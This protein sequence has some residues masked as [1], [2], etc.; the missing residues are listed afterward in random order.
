M[1]TCSSVAAPTMA[2]TW[3]SAATTSARASAPAQLGPRSEQEIR[4]GLEDEIGA[5]RWTSL[6][7]S[8]PDIS[9]EGGG[10][11]DLRPGGVGEDPELRRL[12]IGRAAKLERLGLAEQI[13]PAQWTLKPGLE[14]ALRD[15]GI[16]GDN[17][18][19]MHRAMSG[20]EREPDVARF[21]L[22]GDLPAERVLGRLV[23]RGLHDELKGTAY[24]IVDGVDGRTHYL[25]FSD[26]EM[27]GDAKPGA[28]VETRAYDDA[29]GRKRLSLATRSDLTVDAQV[30]ARG[31][32]WLDRQ[33][34]A[35]ESA[36][37]SGGFGAEVRDAMDRRIN[38]LIEHDLA[39]RQGQR[40]L[41]AR[42][43]L[44]TLRRR[45]LDATAASLSAETGLA[46]RPSGEGD[47]VSGVYR[48]RVT[49]ATGRF[50]MI[51]DGMGFQLVP[52]RPALEQQLGKQIGG[53]MAP[54]GNV[55]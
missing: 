52:W 26:L 17:I 14:L 50:A 33:L 55:D 20:A 7:R 36:L 8:L 10:V 28:I 46:H 19:T 34:L 53:V 39:R 9:D 54:G 45:E 18:K 38:H 24:T 35:K 12:L 16:C 1:S 4:A 48:Q 6:D 41:F 51:D 44:N 13:G 23:E 15:L 37:S 30:S 2:R 43:L 47:H 25:V 42:D 11:A 5:E 27:T 21:A 29:G 40:V 32:T 3:S 22:H 49:L 31:A